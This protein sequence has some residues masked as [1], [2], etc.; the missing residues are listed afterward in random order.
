[1]NTDDMTREELIAHYEHRIACERQSHAD[2]LAAA[3]KAFALWRARLTNLPA[4][5]LESEQ[6]NAFVEAF[7]DAIENMEMG[8]NIGHIITECGHFV[9]WM[10]DDE[11]KP[12]GTERPETAR[13]LAGA[14][15]E[16]LLRVTEGE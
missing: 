13:K 12:G 10:T 3:E 9:E 15:I 7:M 6:A 4:N 5:T 8:Y 1:M 2:R 16:I 14:A 11:N